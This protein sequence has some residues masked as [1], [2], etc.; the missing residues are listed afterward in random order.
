MQPSGFT[1][2]RFGLNGEL[3]VYLVIDQPITDCDASK[4]EGWG[5]QR[6]LSLTPGQDGRAHCLQAG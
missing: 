3:C 4:S 5:R 6:P 2:G 1:A